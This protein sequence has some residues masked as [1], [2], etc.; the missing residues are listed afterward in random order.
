MIRSVV[1]CVFLLCSVCCLYAADVT[2]VTDREDALYSCGEKAGF[3]ISSE[4]ETDCKYTLTLD[5][6]DVIKTGELKITDDAEV[7]YGSVEE[8]G[9]LRCAVQ[10]KDS[11]TGKMKSAVAAAGFDPKKI[12]PAY[13]KL[14]E[15]FDVFW[16]EMKRQLSCIP[17]NIVMEPY[18]SDDGVEIVD[19]KVDCIG[20]NVSG[21]YARPIDAKVKSCPA[22]LFVQGAGVYSSRTGSVKDYASEGFIALEINAHGLSNGQSKEYYSELAKG[23]LQGYSHWGRESRY[24]SYFKGMYL[25]VV[26]ALE[27]LKAQPQWDG[28]V[29]VVYG[30]SQGGAQT[31]A[32]T[33]LDPDVNIIAAAVP[34]MS[35]HAGKIAGWPRMIPTEGDGSYNK[36]IADASS[37]FD[38]V[39]F[40]R[41]SKA[42]AIFTVG[43]IDNVCRPTS[44]YAVYNTFPNKKEIINEPLMDHK[45]LPEHRDVFKQWI[46]E[47][48]EDIK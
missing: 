42:Q 41:K 8:P 18:S 14:T 29:L 17:F 15:D 5:G 6:K 16:N 43:F 31:L 37:F 24:T 25:R 30:S 20:K 21:Y 28:K 9:F 48:I 4:T 45:F 22:I 38:N 3:V 12:K 36:Q 27:F 40:A 32:A 19:I 10:Y 26:R 34:A 1:N 2:V 7:V 44:V 13:D 39:N 33:G 46:L 47:I 23:E 35:D 11:D